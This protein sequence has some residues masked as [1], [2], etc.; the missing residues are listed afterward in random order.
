MNP[1]CEINRY[2]DE[3]TVMCDFQISNPTMEDYGSIVDYT[4]GI[5]SDLEHLFF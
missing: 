3:V 5:V 1:N 4:D 2:G